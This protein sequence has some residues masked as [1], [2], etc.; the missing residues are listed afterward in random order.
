M[1]KTKKLLDFDKN[2]LLCKFKYDNDKC[3]DALFNHNYHCPSVSNIF[4]EKIIKLPVIKQIYDICYNYKLRKETAKFEDDYISDYET[5]DMKWVWGLKAGDDL[6][7]P[8][9]CLYTMNDIDIIYLK[10]E[11][12]YTV[13][14]E[15]M[16]IFDNKQA[17]YNYMN[18]LLDKF[19]QFMKQNGYDT[20]QEFALYEVFTNGININTHFDSLEE[21]YAAFKMIV[22]G[23]VGGSK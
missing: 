4:Y 2:C 11:S 22:K 23:F 16:Y 8:D 9:A 13:G 7:L 20:N 6:C 15:T 1:K 12:K 10:D 5:K 14:I 18:D 21:C 19:T 3:F 17:E